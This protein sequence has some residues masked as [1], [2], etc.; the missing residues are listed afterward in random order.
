METFGCYIEYHSY[1]RKWKFYFF[2]AK[3]DA[4]YCLIWS[5]C[6]LIPVTRTS[7][8]MLNNSDE[9]GHLCLVPDCRGTVFP[10]LR[11][12]LAVG[13]SWPFL[14]WI[15]FLPKLT[16]LRVFIMNE[17]LHFVKCFFCTYW[18]DH[19]CTF[20]CINVVYHI[21]WFATIELLWHLR[22]KSHL[23]VVNDFLMYCWSWFANIFIENF[24]IHIYQGYWPLVLVFCGVFI[25]F[26]YQDNASLIELIWKFFFFFYFLEWL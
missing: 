8:T 17:M 2:L 9:S 10:H 19:F 6:C 20:F 23:I 18:N 21:D 3:L 26:F 22:N 16:L 7:S 25:W 11:M 5:F 24:C 13:F 4:F 12:I 1:L 15:M 14:C